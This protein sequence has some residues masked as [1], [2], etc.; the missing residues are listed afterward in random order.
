MTTQTVL[1][2]LACSSSIFA[3]C[4]LFFASFAL[5]AGAADYTGLTVNGVHPSSASTETVGSGEALWTRDGST[6]HLKGAGPYVVTGSGITNARLL[7]ATNCTLVVTNLDIVNTGAYSPIMCDNRITLM[8]QFAGT[9]SFI[10]GVSAPG[11]ES[12]GNG[13]STINITNL[14]E[15][16]VLTARGGTGTTKDVSG[17]AGIGG[18]FC[19]TINILGGSIFA[20]GGGAAPGIG[21]TE[22]SSDSDTER[23]N[24]FGGTI[25]AQGGTYY[26]DGEGLAGGA[27]LGNG[28]SGR[29]VVN[30]YGGT[31]R[32]DGGYSSAGIGNGPGRAA[33]YIVKIA[34]GRVDA[35]GYGGGAGIGNGW[36]SFIGGGNVYGWIDISGGTVRADSYG[37]AAVDLGSGNDDAPGPFG[38]F[39]T[40]ITG[41]S[42]HCQSGRTSPRPTNEACDFLYRVKVTGL[43]A[44]TPITNLVVD[45][46]FASIGNYG[47]KDMRADADGIAYLWMT[48]GARRFTIN[49]N[50]AWVLVADADITASAD[51]PGLTVNG[52]SITEGA[53]GS[54][55][56]AWT[57]NGSTCYLNGMGPYVVSGSATSSRVT[58][59]HDCSVVV[60]NLFVNNVDVDYP[61][62]DCDGYTVNLLLAGAN[63]FTAGDGRPG[64]EVD[65][66]GNTGDSSTLV[67]SNLTADATLVAQGGSNGAG[68]GS[69]PDIECGTVEIRGG[70]VTAKSGKNGAGIGGGNDGKGGTVRIYG[71]TVVADSYDA[72]ADDIGA[73]Y[74]GGQ[75]TTLICGGSVRCQSGKSGPRPVNA[76]GTA[77]YCVKITGL[78]LNVPV[79][80]LVVD[81]GYPAI[82]DYGLNDVFP[83]ADGNA[84]FWMSNGTR[85]FNVNTNHLWALV[86]D[87]DATAYSVIPTLVVN[88]QSI[89]EGSGGS[90]DTVWEQNGSTTFLRGSGPYVISGSA[91]DP[92]RIRAEASCTVVLSNVTVSATDTA[93]YAPFE[94][95]DYSVDLRLMG[96]N[97]FTAGENRPGVQVVSTATLSITNLE[98]GATLNARGGDNGAGIGGDDEIT[99]GTVNIFGGIIDA[100]GYSGGAGIGGGDGGIGGTVRIYG[101]T[102]RAD[103]YGAEAD[104]IGAGSGAS[105]GATLITGGSVH[106]QSTKAGPRPVNASGTALYCVRISGLVPGADVTSLGIGNPD[107]VN[108]GLNGV[109]ADS[110]GALYLWLPTAD[111]MIGGTVMG[112]SLTNSFIKGFTVGTEDIPSG[113]TNAL[114]R[115]TGYDQ[116][117]GAMTHSPTAL[118]DAALATV[119]STNLTAAAAD[120]KGTNDVAF[121]VITNA[122]SVFLKLRVR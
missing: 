39:Y 55:D 107:T 37:A 17:G 79:T 38:D 72:I 75:G 40:R 122:P 41:G 32:A 52:H 19:G 64:I 80:N 83:N 88:G 118:P 20:Y 97:T 25:V 62:F 91:S 94:C 114:L 58:V 18:M 115:I 48:N 96:V 2:R 7:A 66:T 119:Y 16:A 71:G 4:F 102:V 67:I 92:S 85:W 57:A 116:T 120:W 77:L 63:A 15:N 26:Y 6:I 89:A 108:Y 78:A 3:F 24:I 42:V 65:A 50:R 30:I 87:S 98:P 104:D 31:I 68:I 54:G 47:I 45:A 61:C 84:Y 113:I 33:T 49:T 60:S 22:S 11:I 112:D 59:R 93:N 86:S 8:L 13:Q 109:R 36:D 121:A 69:K 10:G 70:I 14:D 9:N 51:I 110:A 117:T 5:T 21:S 53:G 74:E 56:T 46:G 28:L 44:W 105:A 29:T 100:I 34:G 106:C 76:S 27:G 103:S 23:V 99:C 12:D 35:V 81:S 90:G 1:R 43:G 82:G 101:G 73:G 95:G 111:Y